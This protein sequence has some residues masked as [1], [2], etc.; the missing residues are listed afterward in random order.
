MLSSGTRRAARLLC[1]YVILHALMIAY[2]L[3]HPDI[4]LITDRANERIEQLDHFPQ[5]AGAAAKLAYIGHHYVPGDYL[6]QSLLFEI[7]GRWLLLVV[8]VILCI[9]SVKCVYRIARMLWGT[10]VGLCSRLPSMH[11]CRKP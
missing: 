7:G 4:W 8:Q 3:A 5:I 10:R 2:E 9:L 11:S 1:L 6:V